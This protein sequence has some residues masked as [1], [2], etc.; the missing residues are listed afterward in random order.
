MK[1]PN[2]ISGLV[3]P[4]CIIILKD[5]RG[6]VGNKSVSLRPFDLVFPSLIVYRIPPLPHFLAYLSV[7]TDTL[8]EPL[9]GYW[10]STEPSLGNTGMN[11]GAE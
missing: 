11:C 7:D 10:G 8:D 2:T 3:I 9:K 6:P 5:L 1:L 4:G